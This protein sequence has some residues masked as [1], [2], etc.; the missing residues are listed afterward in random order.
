MWIKQISEA[1]QYIDA[2][3]VRCDL[4][5]ADNVAL[6]P[7]HPEYSERELLA[8]A[9]EEMGLRL[10]R[11]VYASGDWADKERLITAAYALIPV[12]AIAVVMT[13][14]AALKDAIA[15][16]ALLTTGA[17]PDGMVN[18]ADP[19][20]SQWLALAGLTLEQVKSKMA[21]V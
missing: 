8:D 20:V 14:P 21:E 11:S 15:G 12:E 13:T 2:A 3:G 17:A 5:I 4:I 1:G 9:M 6:A 10:Y 18:L 19:R 16:L 7:V